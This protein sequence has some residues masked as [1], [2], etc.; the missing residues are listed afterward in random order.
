[1]VTPSETFLSPEQAQCVADNDYDLPT[2]LTF[3]DDEVER[4]L[5][6]QRQIESFFF[7]LQ[8]LLRQFGIASYLRF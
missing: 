3:L 8:Q 6:R 4:L 2:N 1:M 5:D 7:Q